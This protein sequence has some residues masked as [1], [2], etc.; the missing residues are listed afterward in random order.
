MTREFA[1]VLILNTFKTLSSDVIYLATALNHLV[2]WRFTIRET[3]S[4]L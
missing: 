3:W 4:M 1:K 2:C